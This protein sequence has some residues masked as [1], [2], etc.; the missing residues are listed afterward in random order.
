MSVPTGDLEAEISEKKI[1]WRDWPNYFSRR[2][3]Q[4]PE[5]DEKP[6]QDSARLGSPPTT[7]SKTKSTRTT[8]TKTADPENAWEGFPQ[9][10]VRPDL[11]SEKHQPPTDWK[12][13]D[14]SGYSL[15]SVF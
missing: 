5:E 2:I 10:C 3:I 9:W 14:L 7:P 13:L 15:T 1:Q 6:T 4:E 12:T 8:T 11:L